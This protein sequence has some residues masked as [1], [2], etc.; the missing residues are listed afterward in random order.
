MRIIVAVM[1]ISPEQPELTP[2]LQ[3]TRQEWCDFRQDA[4][5]T[6][7]EADL[8]K[9]HGQTEV[10]SLKEVEE[11]YLPLSRLLSFYVT[12]RQA[13][14]RATSQFLGKPEPKVPF[15]IG[16]AGSVAVGKSTTSRVLQALLS[17]WPDHPHVEVITTDGFLYPNAELERQDLMKRKGFPESYDTPHL[18]RVLHA[19]KS[20]KR[21]VRIPIYS[22][23]YY[24]IVPDQYEVVDQPDIVILEGLNILQTGTKKTTQLSKLFVSD[25]F[26]FSLFVDAKTEIIKKWYI[27]RVLNFS[28]NVFTDPHSYFHYL[29]HL[30]EVEIIDFASRVWCEINEVN[31]IENILPYKGRA[32]L[33]LEKA[34]NHSVQRVYLRKI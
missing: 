30:S 32:Q 31:L 10:V 15:I 27:D 25:F 33:I 3:F 19:I 26:D 14:Y 18:L 23:H 29:T 4:P 16:I 24:D 1:N 21:R 28:R 2:Y 20:G 7:T 34:Q 6:L 8:D 17:R 22:H 9:L 11:I 5:L 12:A 13:L